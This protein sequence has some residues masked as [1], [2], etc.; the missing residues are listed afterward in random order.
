MVT[1]VWWVRH[2]PTHAKCFLGSSDWPADLSDTDQLARLDAALPR[3]GVLVSSDLIR[4]SATADRLHQGRTRLADLSDLR[5]FDFGDWEERTFKDVSQTD[6]EL[7]RAFWDSPGDLTAPGGE[8]WNMVSTR[9]EAAVQK[10]IAEHAG[11]DI[12]AVAHMGVI[13]TQI[14][15]CP[16]MTP[17]KAMGYEIDNLSITMIERDAEEMRLRLVNDCP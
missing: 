12:I 3:G 1:R 9:V 6:P 4:S 13:M 8:S 16:G 7:S 14:A 11:E 17:Y 10:L 2:G 15:R 5:E